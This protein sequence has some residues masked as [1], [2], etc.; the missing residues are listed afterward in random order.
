VRHGTHRA[1]LPTQ[2]G[3][4]DRDVFGLHGNAQCA[5]GD[6][7]IGRGV[8]CCGRVDGA[9]FGSARPAVST[10]DHKVPYHAPFGAADCCGTGATDGAVVDGV[11][12][13]MT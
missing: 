5:R 4:D 9:G 10:V 7:P 6:G 11:G 3:G 13:T 12:S 2:L 8:G 1:R